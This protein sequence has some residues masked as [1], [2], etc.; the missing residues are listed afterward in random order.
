MAQL[1]LEP[2]LKRKSSK[3]GKNAAREPRWKKKEK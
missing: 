3:K 1:D 2:G